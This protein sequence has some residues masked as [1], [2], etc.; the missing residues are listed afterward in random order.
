[1]FT[2]ISTVDGIFETSESIFNFLHTG[3]NL[4]E[5]KMEGNNLKRQLDATR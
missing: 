5:A 3:P 2:L 4:F 1:M